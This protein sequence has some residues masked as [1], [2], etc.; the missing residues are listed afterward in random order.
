MRVKVG[1]NFKENFKRGGLK[2]KALIVDDSRAMRLIIG[3]ILTEIGFEIIEAKD[4]AE[5]MKYFDGTGQVDLAL[6]DWNLPNM[7]GLELITYIRSN[8]LNN[9]ICVIMCTSETEKSRVTDALS[10]GAN[11]YVM[12]PFTR[13][14]ML[15]KLELLGMVRN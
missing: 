7:N 10:A 5:A 8:P 14:V 13:D 15:A 11:E 9:D 12:K 3:K 1:F 4:G 6:V 2:M